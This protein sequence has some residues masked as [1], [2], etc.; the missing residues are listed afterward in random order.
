MQSGDDP[1]LAPLIGRR[2]IL[3]SR[4]THRFRQSFTSCNA[5]LELGPKRVG[6][7]GDFDA[8]LLDDPHAGSNGMHES[9]GWASLRGGVV[10]VARRT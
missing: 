10:L 1:I 4:Q 7:V 3:L 9:Q 5:R 2:W 6:F 8:R